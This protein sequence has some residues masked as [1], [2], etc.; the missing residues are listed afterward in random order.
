MRLDIRF[1]SSL[2]SVCVNCILLLFLHS[3]MLLLIEPSCL[4]NP[5]F[6][7]CDAV[8]LCIFLNLC[9]GGFFSIVGRF[10]F[11]SVAV[12]GVDVP[13]VAIFVVLLHN[14]CV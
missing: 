12:I 2:T 3:F 7:T 6:S 9:V 11:P 14:V 4:C 1:A 13:A 10:Y 8:F 5:H